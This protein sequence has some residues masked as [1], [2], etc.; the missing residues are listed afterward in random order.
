MTKTEL[1]SSVSAKVEGLT[2]KQTE[3][4]I[5]A[6]FAALVEAVRDSGHFTYPGFGTFKMKERGS[7]PGRNPRTGE[8]IMIPASKTIGFQPG[9]KL[10]AELNLSDAVEEEAAKVVE[11]AETKKCCK[12]SCKKEAAAKKPAAKKSKK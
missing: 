4:V 10:K 1:V 9:S 8:P 2:K 3:S 7:R 12:K 5:N 11:V 6:T